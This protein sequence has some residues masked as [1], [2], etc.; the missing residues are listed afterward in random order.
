MMDRRSV[1][2]AGL[3]SL[4]IVSVAAIPVARSATVPPHDRRSAAWDVAMAEFVAA[5]QAMDTQEERKSSGASSR[6]R[7]P[8]SIPARQT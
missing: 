8:F 4:A 3:H 5:K 6:P 7:P 1:L 2:N